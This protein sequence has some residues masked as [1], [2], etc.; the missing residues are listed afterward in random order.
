MAVRSCLLAVGLLHVPLAATPTER[1]RLRVELAMTAANSGYALVETFEVSDNGL[2]E[3]V[4]FRELELVARQVDAA[5]VVVAGDVDLRR[6][7]EV[8]GRVRMVV[9]G[10]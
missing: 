2:Q 9:V 6:V 4:A 3:D 7:Q 10:V 5:A 8:A 1:R